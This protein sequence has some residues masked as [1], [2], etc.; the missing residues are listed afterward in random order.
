MAVITG[1]G[2]GLGRATAEALAAAGAS[3]V[4]AA[5]TEAEINLLADQIKARG[6]AALAIPTDVTRT[7]AVDSLV[8]LTIR[9]FRRI[10]ILVNNAGLVSP[11]GRTWE[12]DPRR[13]Q[14]LL[15]V[16]IVGPYL[17]ARAM[18]PQ[19][20]DRGSGRIINVTSGA[21]SSNV[22]GWSAYC[23]SKAALDRFTGVLA[24]EL[25]GSGVVAAGVSP[26]LVDSDMQAEIRRATR[27]AFPRVEEFRAYQ[28]RG[29]LRP[30][31]EPARL[32]VWL[33]SRFG[34]DQNGA[35][36][37]LDDDEMRQR[38]ARDLGEPPLPGRQRS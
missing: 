5:R 26:G 20:L 32:I 25:E 34:A 31:E 38:L 15:E 17:C 9:A 14:R 33:A 11:V 13:W 7:A 1:A 22:V 18:L 8:T 35:I 28:A 10:D 37:R 3:V 27:T 21:A 16:N 4:L 24:A 12:V 30:P 19:M 36:L 2:R 29:Q 6:G 23:A